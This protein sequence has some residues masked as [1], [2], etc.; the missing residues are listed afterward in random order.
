[1][2]LDG[3]DVAV[4]HIA[5]EAAGARAQAQILLSVPVDL[6]VP[7]PVSRARVVGDLVVLEARVGR[8]LHQPR[9]LRRYR[10]FWRQ[11]GDA[12]RA[13]EASVVER[14]RVGREVIGFPAEGA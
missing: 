10:L 4:A 2:T 12:G 14:E 11:A 6:V 13:P 9:V 5:E 3:L 1:V 8:E 7:R